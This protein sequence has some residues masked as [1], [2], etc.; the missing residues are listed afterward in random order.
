MSDQVCIAGKQHRAWLVSQDTSVDEEWVDRCI[1]LGEYLIAER[2]QRPIGFL[3]WSRFW[4]K[5]PYIDMI[6]VSP[7]A[8]GTGAGRLLLSHLEKVAG[9]SGIEIIMT[10]CESDE[11]EAFDWHFTQGF[12]PVGEIEV[13]TIQTS[14]ELFL[15]KH[16]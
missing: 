5:V 3:R 11:R 2:H 4:G 14:R 13:P 16:L 15:V 10:S 8:Q 12:K 7:L 9:G 6:Y 1:G